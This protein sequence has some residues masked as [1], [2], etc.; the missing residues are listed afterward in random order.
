MQAEIIESLMV[1][2]DTYKQNLDKLVEQ[3]QTI[4]KGAIEKLEGYYSILGSIQESYRKIDS[5]NTEGKQLHTKILRTNADMLLSQK[6]EM[7]SLQKEKL[8]RFESQVQLRA[9]TDQV[10]QITGKLIK[11]HNQ[12]Q[13][14]KSQSS[15]NKAHL[16]KMKE[17]L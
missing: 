6:E 7:D 12:A 17:A 4:E 13:S 15:V 2:V 1:K 3:K 11:Q 10:S 5:Y 16:S 14:K 9:E 8:E